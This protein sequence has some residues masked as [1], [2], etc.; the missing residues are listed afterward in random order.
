MKSIRKQKQFGFS[1]LYAEDE[2]DEW[3]VYGSMSNPRKATNAKKKKK[4]GSG[5]TKSDP[6]E[7]TWPDVQYDDIRVVPDVS[8]TAT[9]RQGKSVKPSQKTHLKGKRK[10]V[11]IGVASD[12]LKPKNRLIQNREERGN[13]KQQTFRNLLKRHGF[14]KFP[15]EKYEADHVIDYTFGGEDKTENL[16]PL[17]KS[18]HTVKTNN[19]WNKMKIENGKYKGSRV[20]EL[21]SRGKTFK[22]R[23]FKIK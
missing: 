20:K 16:W 10:T 22:N 23:W 17:A 8:T 1:K 7:V 14:K 15:S 21:R 12:N 4:E 11:T 5:L 3:G 2:G 9:S 13:T 19:V 6:L 18:K